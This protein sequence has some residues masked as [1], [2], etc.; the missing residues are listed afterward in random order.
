MRNRNF[1]WCGLIQRLK[2]VTPCLFLIHVLSR[3]LEVIFPDCK[4]NSLGKSLDYLCLLFYRTW[5][6]VPS[7]SGVT[8]MD[9]GMENVSLTL[10]GL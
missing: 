8:G 7:C 6:N 4:R 9:W 2:C 10:H 3:S 5:W 1:N